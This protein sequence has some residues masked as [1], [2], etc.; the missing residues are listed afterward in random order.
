MF[1]ADFCFTFLWRSQQRHSDCVLIEVV[2]GMMS[3][4]NN[5]MVMCP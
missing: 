4:M 3:M 2:V 5:V 1:H